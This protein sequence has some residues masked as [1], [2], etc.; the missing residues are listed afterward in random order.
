MT[1][2][3]YRTLRLGVPL[4]F[5]GIDPESGEPLEAELVVPPLNVDSLESLESRIR[6]ISTLTIVEGLKVL[7]DVL[8]HSVRRNYK[9][10]PRWL[11]TQTIGPDNLQE[12]LNVVMDVSGLL[13]KELEA[14]KAIAAA[15]QTQ[16]SAGTTCAAS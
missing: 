11:I 14:K 4:E 8:E 2:E 9:N 16:T 5:R 13:R 7:T 1:I 6:G 10:V 15:T 12:Y 3:P